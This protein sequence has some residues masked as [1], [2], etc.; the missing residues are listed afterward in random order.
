MTKTQP[1]SRRHTHARQS[2]GWFV[3]YHPDKLACKDVRF[4]S[5]FAAFRY[6]LRLKRHP[7]PY[8]P[9]LFKGE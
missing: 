7:Y 8:H 6:W 5:W 9:K 2:A 1:I 4:D 3:R